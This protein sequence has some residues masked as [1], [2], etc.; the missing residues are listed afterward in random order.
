MT[1]PPPEPTIGQ[2]D[3]EPN[4]RLALLVTRQLLND[5]E[6]RL[7]IEDDDLRLR[8]AA[9]RSVL[10]RLQEGLGDD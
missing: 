2:D 5:V 1:S 9:V 6:P 10:R 7:P 4:L 8:L 3:E